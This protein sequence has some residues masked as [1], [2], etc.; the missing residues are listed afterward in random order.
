[1]CNNKQNVNLLRECLCL[2][3]RDREEPTRCVPG[4]RDN[5]SES[6]PLGIWLEREIVI[7]WDL[8]IFEFNG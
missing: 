4:C 5:E 2:L 1:M 7:T 3:T 6:D 8:I